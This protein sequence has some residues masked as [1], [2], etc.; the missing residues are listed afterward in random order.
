M[1]NKYKN[2]PSYIVSKSATARLS[3]QRFIA[4]SGSS[5]AP[6]AP[7]NAASL[8][9]SLNGKCVVWLRADDV[10][11]NGT[12]V[13]M[14]NDKSGFNN[15]FS[16]STGASQAGYN[17]T[18]SFRGMP[19]V[20][21]NGSSHRYFTTRQITELTSSNQATVFAFIEFK[22]QTNGSHQVIYEHSTN[23]NSA[24]GFDLGLGTSAGSH[25]FAAFAGLGTNAGVPHS[26]TGTIHTELPPNTPTSGVILMAAFD[27]EA[28]AND[29]QVY[30][31]ANLGPVPRTTV[32]SQALNANWAAG[33]SY[34]GGRAGG[35]LFFSGAIMEIMVFNHILSGSEIV[36]IQNYL[37]GRY[38]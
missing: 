27:K 34:L 8:S 19:A 4:G 23:H 12:Q 21:F 29:D 33:L 32:S 15:N 22:K 5:S 35:T 16:N 9:S 20:E 10:V 31:S 11:L 30:M 13:L 24:N 6:S 18:S 26:M 3:Q 2:K 38:F 36:Q 25:P 28:V 7:F 37:S 14:W 1:K 17:A